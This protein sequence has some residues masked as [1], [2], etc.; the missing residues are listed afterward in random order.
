MTDFITNTINDV[1]LAGVALLMLLDT[2]FPLIPSEVVL[3]F[4][5][6]L[7]SQDNF[8]FWP[9]VAAAT[10]GSTVG[11]ILPYEVGR[12]GGRAVVLR[13]HRVLHVNE[14]SL[15]RFDRLTARWGDPVVFF[16]RMVPVHRAAISIPAGIGRMGRARFIVLSAAGSLIWN[17]VL[18]YAG[19]RLGRDWG[20]AEDAVHEYAVIALPIMALAAVAVIVWWWRWGRHQLRRRL[21]GE[22]SEA[23]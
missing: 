4:A 15:D 1:G 13:Y 11:S 20:R 18:I 17:T 22:R 6:Y 5:G 14:A 9:A 3:P 16:A 10:I 7:V 23:T 19:Y 12:Y 21:A 8:G 2:A